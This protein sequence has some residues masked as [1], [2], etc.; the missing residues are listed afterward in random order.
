MWPRDGVGIRRSRT[1]KRARNG[2]G[3]GPHSDHK[4]GGHE[5]ASAPKADSCSAAKMDLFDSRSL[6]YGVGQKL[7][8]GSC[9][10]VHVGEP[11]SAAGLERNDPLDGTSNR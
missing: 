1:A 9:K 3:F 10:G 5:V 6:R 4:V 2:N 8:G 11:L 7:K